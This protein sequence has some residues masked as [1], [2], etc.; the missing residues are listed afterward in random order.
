M[1]QGRWF[2]LSLNEQC[3]LDL[4]SQNGVASYFFLLF[5]CLPNRLRPRKGKESNYVSYLVN[6]LAYATTLQISIVKKQPPKN[7]K[8]LLFF[9]QVFL[10]FGDVKKPQ[11]TNK[12]N[13]WEDNLKVTS[14]YFCFNLG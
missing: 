3:I 13:F 9:P 6:T 4:V 5:F 14:S 10:S 8:N 7:K 11:I 1:S 2:L 12:I